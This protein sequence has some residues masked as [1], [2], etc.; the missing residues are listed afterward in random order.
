MA[1]PLE[2]VHGMDKSVIFGNRP[3]DPVELYKFILLAILEYTLAL[4]RNPPKNWSSL[5]NQ[6]YIEALPR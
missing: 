4:L 3:E 1:L 2:V 6:H 5:I